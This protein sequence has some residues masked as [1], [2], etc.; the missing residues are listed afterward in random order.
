M[1]SIT[2]SGN[3]CKLHAHREHDSLYQAKAYMHL[4]T[5]S[6]HHETF[7]R[8]LHVFFFLRIDIL[9]L[10]IFRENS[11]YVTRCEIIIIA[12]VVVRFNVI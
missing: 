7:C 2:Y 8:I 1:R 10:L 5:I 12:V 6:M 4:R 3:N 9:S 11:A